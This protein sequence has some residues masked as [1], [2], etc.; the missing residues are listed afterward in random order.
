MAVM[1]ALARSRPIRIRARS[2]SRE[3]GLPVAARW[4]ASSRRAWARRLRGKVRGAPRARLAVALARR[5]AVRA[6]GSDLGTLHEE[7]W[8]SFS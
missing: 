5:R 3:M 2:A 7:A 6:D 1:S 4:A 8:L